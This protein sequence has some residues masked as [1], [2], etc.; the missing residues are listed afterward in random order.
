MRNHQSIFHFFDFCQRSRS[1]ARITSLGCLGNYAG[2]GYPALSVAGILASG[3]FAPRLLAS[4]HLV[5]V[6]AGVRA[7]SSR[8]A[9]M[10]V[11]RRCL[12]DAVTGHA[13][14]R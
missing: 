13:T 12:I 11:P 2:Y 6:V 5:S 9:V 4:V 7:Q 1:V 8:L 3:W 14:I 10:G